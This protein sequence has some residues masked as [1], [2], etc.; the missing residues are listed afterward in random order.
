MSSAYTPEGSAGNRSCPVSFVVM[1]DGPPISAGEV[2][3]TTAPEMALPC[4]SLTVPMRAPVRPCAAEIRGATTHAAAQS[5][6]TVGHERLWDRL[7][8]RAADAFTCSLCRRR[9]EDRPQVTSRCATAAS[10]ERRYAATNRES[11]GSSRDSAGFQDARGARRMLER[12]AGCP[13]GLL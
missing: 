12:I 7:S 8:E 13:E 3:R 1:L 2:T 5:T 9:V 6:N 4:A 11:H 10:G